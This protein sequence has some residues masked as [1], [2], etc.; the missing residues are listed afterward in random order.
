[1][2]LA[3]RTLDATAPFTAAAARRGSAED[4]LEL[5]ARL[6]RLALS[7]ARLAGRH[8]R[9]ALGPSPHTGFQATGSSTSLAFITEE[10]QQPKQQQQQHQHGM[11][12][13]QAVRSAPSSCHYAA[14]RGRGSSSWPRTAI[15]QL[16]ARRRRRGGAACSVDGGEL[17][18]PPDE[19]ARPWAWD[20]ELPFTMLSDGVQVGAATERMQACLLYC[21]CTAPFTAPVL[22]LV[23][24]LYCTRNAAATALLQL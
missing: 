6:Q 9:H 12:S 16:A 15:G 11:A 24:H 7:A 14:S 22:H 19:K 10:Q 4:Q 2:A 23:L 8:A 1:L 5:S 21:T 3:A 17:P 13:S 18:L 20:V